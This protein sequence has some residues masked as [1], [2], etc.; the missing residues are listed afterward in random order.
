[1][2][3]LLL[4]RSFLAKLGRIASRYRGR[5]PGRNGKYRLINDKHV[6]KRRRAQ[7]PLACEITHITLR[8]KYANAVLQNH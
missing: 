4:G 2:R 7:R 5:M 6:P 8:A 1:M 3:P